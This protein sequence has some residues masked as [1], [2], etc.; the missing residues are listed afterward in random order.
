MPEAVAL[1]SSVLWS[2]TKRDFL[3]SL[4]EAGQFEPKWSS[5]TLG[6]VG[7]NYRKELIKGG[8]SEADA[9]RRADHLIANMRDAF[10]RAEISGYQQRVGTYGLP[11]PNDEHVVAAA[12][13]A[14]VKTIVTDNVP[15]FPQDKLPPGTKI[16]TG[17]EFARRTAK[18]NP[19][20]AL[21]TVEGMAA[22]SGRHGPKMTVED[23]LRDMRERQKWPEA[24]DIINRYA[25]ET[26]AIQS[27]APAGTG[28]QKNAPQ[29]Q[30]GRPQ[31]RLGRDRAEAI[32]GRPDASRAGIRSQRRPER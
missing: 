27:L 5:D 11:D 30:A 26:G 4:A 1:D 10:T 14:R 29:R 22:R 32:R 28:Q 18:A 16:V 20:R 12:D 15:D 8:S 3:L 2:G 31:Q 7:Y 9:T 24:A 17:R 6:E 21:Q 25:V 13:H 23:V 19:R